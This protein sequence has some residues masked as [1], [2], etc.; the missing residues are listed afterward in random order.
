MTDEPSRHGGVHLERGSLVGDYRIDEPISQGGKGEVYRATS[1]E[2]GRVCALKVLAPEIA[3]DDV[4]RRRFARE[5][6]IAA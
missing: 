4:F 1:V 5:M 6:R 2:L 3:G